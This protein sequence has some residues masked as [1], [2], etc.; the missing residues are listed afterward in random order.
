MDMGKKGEFEEERMA[1]TKHGVMRKQ[2]STWIF[3]HKKTYKKF[4]LEYKER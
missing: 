4:R 3:R 1:N 2:L